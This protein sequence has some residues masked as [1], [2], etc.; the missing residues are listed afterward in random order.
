MSYIMRS[1]FCTIILALCIVFET[2]AESSTSFLE[3]YEVHIINRL[4]TT[5]PPLGLHCK[6]G[7]DD[8][9]IHVP[10][11]GEDFHWHFKSNF[12][13]TT[14]FYCYFWSGKKR[15][16]FDVYSVKIQDSCYKDFHIGTGTC[17][18]LVKDDGFYSSYTNADWNKKYDWWTLTSNTTKSIINK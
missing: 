10:R 11:V 18:W 9:G 13:G 12:W 16:S 8:L 1:F 14:R 4:T 17:Y 6:S 7:D 2:N 15:Q 5:S 3:T